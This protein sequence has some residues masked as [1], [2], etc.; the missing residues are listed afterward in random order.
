MRINQPKLAGLLA[1]AFVFL[2]TASVGALAQ[3]PAQ[4]VPNGQSFKIQ[5]IVIDRKP[6]SFR[7]RDTSNVETI[8][9]LTPVTEVRTHRHGVFGGGKPYA[10]TYILRGLRL[11]AEGVGNADGALVAKLVKFD[12]QDLRTAQALQQTDEMTRENQ[13]RIAAEEKARQEEAQKL[14]GQIAENQALTAQA[15]ASA[16]AANARAE[17][18][19]KTAD[20][21]NNRINGLNDYDP[22]RNW[23][24]Y[25][26]PG[27]AILSLAEKQKIDA[28]VAW[29]RA[30]PNTDAWFVEIVGFADTTGNTAYN[31][32]LSERR[33]NAV[34]GYLVAKHNLPL[35][36]L[37]QP[38][39]YG[40]S[41]PVANN[42]TASGRA[43][44]R[45]V[46]I[47][48]LANKGIAGKTD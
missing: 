23:T 48:I 31:R 39:G 41:K 28:G 25:F 17:A 4:M 35:T 45:R 47:K 5:G 38:F 30:Q 46:E 27:S 32:S 16:D 42:R 36:R 10:A 18:A 1:T 44:N 7:V 14:A 6:D 43:L 33:A 11:Q 37:I 26:R 13:A 20:R 21:A 8:V 34:I 24:I 29:V 9:I 40:D 22:V 2:L 15:Q 12:E 19:Q 3:N